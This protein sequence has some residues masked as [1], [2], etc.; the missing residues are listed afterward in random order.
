MHRMQACFMH[1]RCAGFGHIMASMKTVKA[2]DKLKS[3]RER[4]GLSIRDMAKESGYGDKW[5]SYRRYES[6]Y[7]KDYLPPEFVKRI[8]HAL[9]DR[10]EPAI[11]HDEVWLD[12]AGVS[13]GTSGINDAI[14]AAERVEAAQR[15][16]KGELV[17]RECN[18]SPQAGAGALGE[19]EGGCSDPHSTTGI[20]VFPRQYI[21]SYIP[22]S[23]G[24]VVVRVQG[25]SMEP[26]FRAGDRVVVDTNHK[27]L[28]PDG[29]YVFWNGIG[30]SM[31][32]LQFIPRSDPP[33]VR[34]ISVNTTY[35]TDILP[36]EDVQICGRVVGRWDFL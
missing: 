9:V 17:V 13:P 6:D 23:N 21:E 10:G 22:N 1:V 3:F 14:R 32:Q 7:K 8:I 19:E 28:N 36:L 25:N 12:L 30:I 16:S 20:W 27:I 31:K 34:V 33:Q 4:A 35:P 5:T 18:V 2:R 29:V 24:L 26:S 11:T 15:V